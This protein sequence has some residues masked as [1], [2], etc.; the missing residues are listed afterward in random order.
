MDPA[1]DTGVLQGN[2]MY[3]ITELQSSYA[4]LSD[5]KVVVCGIGKSVPEE[6]RARVMG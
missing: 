5:D 6:N 3:R 2:R 1:L 4:K